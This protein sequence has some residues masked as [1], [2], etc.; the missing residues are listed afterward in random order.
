MKKAL[1]ALMFLAASMTM[2]ADLTVTVPSAAVAGASDRCEEL[3][4]T[5][6][7]RAAEW[8]NDLCATVFTR[9]GLRGF[10]A[11]QER[12]DSTQTITDAVAAALSQFDLDWAEPFTSAYCGDNTI[13]VEFGEECDDGNS[14]PGDGCDE[15]CLDE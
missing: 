10:V 8:D 13:D 12:K 1:A 5:F 2:A 4:L 14:T 9:I 11:S 15:Q 7:V 6:K 3:R